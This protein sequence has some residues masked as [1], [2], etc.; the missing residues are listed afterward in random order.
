MSVLE[1]VSVMHLR[2]TSSSPYLLC[3]SGYNCASVPSNISVVCILINRFIIIE[4][5]LRVEGLLKHI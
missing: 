1:I 2:I 3:S 4:P 5:L